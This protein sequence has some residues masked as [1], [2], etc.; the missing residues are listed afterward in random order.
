M[1]AAICARCNNLLQL[2]TTE[3]DVNM[4]ALVV[5]QFSMLSLKNIASAFM[6]GLK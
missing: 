3:R 1:L 2:A 5:R 4:A 6:N